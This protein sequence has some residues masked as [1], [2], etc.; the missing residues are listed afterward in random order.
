MRPP[1]ACCEIE[2]V[3]AMKEA[4]QGSVSGGSHGGGQGQSTPCRL[5]RSRT[6]EFCLAQPGKGIRTRRNSSGPRQTAL[7]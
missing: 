5:L 7:T 6:Y 4:L 2:S 1:A 3:T